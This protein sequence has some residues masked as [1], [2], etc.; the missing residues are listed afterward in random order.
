[1]DIPVTDTP[2]EDLELLPM[3]GFKEASWN[4]GNCKHVVLGGEMGAG[5][6]GK[7]KIVNPLEDLEKNWCCS[8]EE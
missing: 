6:C 7:Y 1:M 3:P 8:W 4:C 2:Q 5:E